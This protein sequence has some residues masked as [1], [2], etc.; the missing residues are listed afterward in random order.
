MMETKKNTT[1]ILENLKRTEVRNRAH[2]HR[3][4]KGRGTVHTIGDPCDHCRSCGEPEA[5]PDGLCEKCEK[6]SL[7]CEDC[8]TF[9]D[10]DD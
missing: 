8:G 4:I 10:D 5:D 1:T 6:C 9:A 2:R 3:I 7:C